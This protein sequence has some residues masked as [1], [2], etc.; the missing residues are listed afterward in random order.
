MNLALS[1]EQRSLRAAAR[2]A[3]SRHATLAAA[4]AALEDPAARPDLWPTARQAGWPGLLVGEDRGGAGLGALDAMLVLIEAGR[5]LAGVPLLGHL[6]AS[7]L[8]DGADHTA[9]EAVADGTR[10]AAWLPA[11]PP[12]DV[13]AGW[14]VA[15]LAGSARVPAPVLGSEGALSGEVAW[16]LDAPGADLLVVAAVREDG[17]PVGCLVEAAAAKIEAVEVYDATRLIGHVSFDAAPADVLA[18][19]GAEELAGAWY[20]SQA[21][22][23]AESLGAVE[24]CLEMSVAYAKERVTFG[25]V[26]GSYQAIKHSLVEILR[27]RENTYS[28]LVYAAWAFQSARSELPLAASAARSAGGRALDYATRAAIAVHG[29]IGATWEHDAPLFFR[30]AQI[31]RRLLG[32]SADATDRV[33]GEV[34]ATARR[35]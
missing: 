12:G 33:A 14:S 27:L 11:R 24:T 28:L 6:P 32:G 31:S 5:G 1:D 3:F 13:T 20:L 18:G 34:L 8:L 16:V 21:L 26:I 17:T 19:I 9:T 22:L 2:H 30:R 10:R 23:A 15:Q 25:R 35:G 4:R 7:L 29:G